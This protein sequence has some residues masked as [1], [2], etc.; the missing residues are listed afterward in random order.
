MRTL[1]EVLAAHPL[2]FE[3]ELMQK[4][5]IV[6]G[7]GYRRVLLD[8]PVGY[9][10]TVIATAIS[11]MLEPELT[12]VLVPP[13]LIVQWVKWINSIPGA[14]R[15][16]A[17]VG[18]PKHRAAYKLE[19]FDFIIMSYQVFNNDYDR[20]TRT[21]SGHEVLTIVDECQALKGRGVLFKHV[22]DFAAAR[23]LIL[24]SGTIMSK[25]GDAYAYIKL[26]TPEIYASYDRFENT[27]VEARNIFK[28][29]TKWCN[30][31]LL[32]AN[33]SARRVFRTKE[34]VHSA[35][36]KARYV[37][38]YYD[39]APDH[40]ALYKRLMEEMLLVLDDG[41]KIDATTA[42]KL[43]HAA[44][45]IITN[46][47]VYSGDPTKRSAVFDLIDT[48]TDEIDLGNLGDPAAGIPRS[49]KL[50]LWTIY[51]KTSAA[52]LKHMQARLA[53][54][55]DGSKAVAAYG[56]VNS[57]KS[58]A[59]FLDDE[60]TVG[61]VAQPGSAGAGLNP[62]HL[63]WHC[64]FIEIP[65]TTIPFVQSSGRIDRKGQKFNPI[66]RLFV[67]RGTIQEQLLKNL[68]E[69]DRL[70]QIASGTKQGIKNLI[71]P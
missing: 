43:Y 21:C 44:Q 14:G 1:E 7:A 5:D 31:D 34:E 9:G 58:I 23:D 6:K 62:Q 29:P 41:S 3:L 20:L 4:I 16:L 48:V 10:K 40:M 66:I 56:A 69:N 17:F 32:T 22:R 68:F 61:L 67:A 24:M 65:T 64:G 51:Q 30:M 19:N 47:D 2:P 26:L 55:K 59:A 60:Q 42:V 39:L 8:L 45:Q 27:H 13:I 12:V 57:K 71:F 18:S 52:V 53:L 33:L 70:V 28:V 50:I 35:L 63:C 11:L 36:P 15:A 49:S 25:P 37:P 46:Y 54:R 38:I